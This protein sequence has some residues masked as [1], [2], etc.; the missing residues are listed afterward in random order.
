[1][2]RQELATRTVSPEL[3]AHGA[4]AAKDPTRAG[5]LLIW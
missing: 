3:H 2:N 4:E 1:M 5:R